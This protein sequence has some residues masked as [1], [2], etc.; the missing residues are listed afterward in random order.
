MVFEIKEIVFFW[1]YLW[2]KFIYLFL[3]FK[4]ELFIEFEIGSLVYK[5]LTKG[6]FELINKEIKVS[7]RKIII[8]L[9]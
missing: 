5:S 7:L 1:N 3:F 4:V 2:N 6:N 8:F 9:K